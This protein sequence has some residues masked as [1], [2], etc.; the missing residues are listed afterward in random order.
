MIVVGLTSYFISRGLRG[1]HSKYTEVIVCFIQAVTDS[2][3]LSLT[4]IYIIQSVLS[5]IVFLP[6]FFSMWEPD[7]LSIFVIAIDAIFSYLY[8]G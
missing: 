4:S 5:I 8:V 6:A 1:E 2:E 3:V 7:P